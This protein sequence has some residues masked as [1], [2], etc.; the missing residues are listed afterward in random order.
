[1]FMASYTAVL[2]IAPA[3]SMARCIVQNMWVVVR[4]AIVMERLSVP[5]NVKRGG[6]K[7]VRPLGTKPD[8][9]TSAWAKI[10]LTIML[11]PAESMFR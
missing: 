4:H 9:L 6:L 3:I 8:S 1:M 10:N 5:V 7:I 2:A 11:H